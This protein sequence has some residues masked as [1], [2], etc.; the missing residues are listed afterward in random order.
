[1]VVDTEYYDVLEV[2]VDATPDEIKKAY[3]KMAVKTHPDK[4]PG[5]EQAKA[6]FQAVS[7]A[8]QVLSDPQLRTIYDE[9]GKEMAV[10]QEGFVDDPQE[11]MAMIF[12]GESFQPWIGEISLIKD[13]MNMSQI[14]EEHEAEQAQA[15]AAESG[16]NTPS[17]NL[18]SHE[19]EA[20]KPTIGTHV[21]TP[22]LS[23]KELIAKK[24]AAEK[25]KRKEELQ[26]LEKEQ[27]EARVKRVDDLTKNLERKLDAVTQQWSQQYLNGGKR[28]P[29]DDL[30]LDAF[31][32]QMQAEADSLKME[33]FGLELLHTIG[34]VYYT[35]ANICIKSQKTW[36]GVGGFLHSAKEKGTILKDGWNTLST[37]MNAANTIKGMAEVEESELSQEDRVRMEQ[38][39]MGNVLVAVWAGS[40]YELQG[41]LRAVSDNVL[42]NKEIPATTRLARA[43]ALL[44]LGRVFKNTTRSEVENEE[45]LQFE[46]LATEAMYK[47]EKKHRFFRKDK[48]HKDHHRHPSSD[49][50]HRSDLE[51]DTHHEHVPPYEKY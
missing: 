33:S 25:K 9:K 8:Y 6:K 24:K 26:K 28:T 42:Y 38:G 22:E 19:S 7:Q 45:A 34:Q 43:R 36:F 14:M 17:Q 21:S 50:E 30:L 29:A 4:N 27:Q 1:M 13:M 35:R 37:A 47:K 48:T 16:V 10:P 11:L 49:K 5:D 32:K 31:R 51:S 20:D 3:R 15:E 2:S 40:R 23:P 12:G 18:L 44:E 41:I 39:I 46:R